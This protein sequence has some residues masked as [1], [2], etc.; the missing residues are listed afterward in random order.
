[1]VDFSKTKK[2][3]MTTNLASITMDPVEKLHLLDENYS[4]SVPT[5]EKHIIVKSQVEKVTHVDEKNIELV[6]KSGIDKVQPTAGF[7]VEVFLSGSD[8]RLFRLFEEDLVDLH[9]NTIE[10]GFSKYFLMDFDK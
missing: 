5:T 2:Q 4:N 6:L 9:G 3:L 8:G 1:M 10:E 7:L